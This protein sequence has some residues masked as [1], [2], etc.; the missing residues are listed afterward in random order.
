MMGFGVSRAGLTVGVVA[1][2]AALVVSITAEHVGT[3]SETVRNQLLLREIGAVYPGEFDNDPLSE[4]VS[5]M[6][7][8]LPLTVYPLRLKGELV[9]AVVISTTPEG[10][11]G[12]ITLAIG[13]TAD[14]AVTGVTVIEH[15]ETVGVGD[16]IDQRKSDWLA[17]FTGRSLDGSSSAEWK[18][19]R[20][21]GSF[22][23]LSGATVSSAAVVRAVQRMLQ[24]YDANRDRSQRGSAAG[25]GESG[26]E[27][28]E[29]QPALE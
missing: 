1:I 18:V 7:P 4:R 20:D 19:T 16:R 12:P 3:R 9:G 6:E 2:V 5:D 27:S 17:L 25:L 24:A 15:E 26:A 23:E 11:S 21:G 13:V 10:Y 29:D 14:G 8:A 28:G 22:D